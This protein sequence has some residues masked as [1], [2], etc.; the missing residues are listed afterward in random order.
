MMKFL[1]RVHVLSLL[2]VS[3]SVLP[4]AARLHAQTVSIPASTLMPVQLAGHVPMKIGERLGARLLYPVYAANQLAIPAGCILQ[5]HVVQLN[6]DKQRR[7][8]ARLWG[9]FTPYHIPVVQFDDLVLPDGTVLPVVSRDATDGAPVLRLSTP[10]V[11]TKGSVV[12]QQ[13]TSLKQQLEDDIALVTA[14]GRGDR[15]VQFLYKQLP[16]HPERIN[17]GTA[18]TVELAQPLILTSTPNSSDHHEQPDDSIGPILKKSGEQKLT[19]ENSW[20]IHAYLKQTISSADEKPGNKFDAV[21][22]EPV[23]ENNH[24]LVVPQGA[25]LIGTV[26][27]AKPARSFGRKGKLRFNFRELKLPDG[28]VEHVEGS[29]AGVDSNASSGLQLDPEGEVQPKPQNRVIVPLVL[30]VLASRAFDEDGSQAANG[31]VASN[32][33]GVIGRIVGIVA[34][35][36]NVAAGIG[37]YGAALSFYSRWIARGQ[38]VVLAKN[39]RVEIITMPRQNSLNPTAAS[40]Q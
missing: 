18:W 2:L 34:S 39:T 25:V 15:L 16:Y 11:R 14:P 36:R 33:F 30:S 5:G 24:V 12:S 23:F 8:H 38:Q 31:A 22:A 20:R 13:I 27:Q 9:D 40:P 28:F 4:S 32:G 26:T 17:A 29:L 10:S 37:Y 1:F 3:T 6:P 21:V 7:V 35:S 19:A